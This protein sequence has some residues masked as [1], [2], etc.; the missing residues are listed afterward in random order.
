M[1]EEFNRIEKQLN[2][3]LNTDYDPIREKNLAKDYIQ[4]SSTFN[5]YKNESIAVL[6]QI[7]M[8]ISTVMPSYLTKMTPSVVFDSF[9]APFKRN[10]LL[11]SHYESINAN[12]AEPNDEYTP[13]R[14]ECFKNRLFKGSRFFWFI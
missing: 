8:L 2:Q 14:N 12:I 10:K 1:R 7:F 4:W 9:V 5:K 6:R 3:Y 11:K 13:P